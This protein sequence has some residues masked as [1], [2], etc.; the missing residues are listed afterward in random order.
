MRTGSLDSF[1]QSSL[2]MPALHVNRSAL[3]KRK[4]YRDFHKRIVAIDA[5]VYPGGLVSPPNPALLVIVFVVNNPPTYGAGSPR[6]SLRGTRRFH[7][8]TSRTT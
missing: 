2:K 3:A 8:R 6:P 7:E 1:R 5:C 4:G